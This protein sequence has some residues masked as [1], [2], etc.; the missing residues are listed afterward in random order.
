VTVSSSDTTRR[1]RRWV[2][3]AVGAAAVVTLA[4]TGTEILRSYSGPVDMHGNRVRAEDAVPPISKSSAVPA[5]GDDR[6]VVKSVGL[7]VPLGALNAVDGV[8]EPPGFTSAYWVRNEGVPPKE[9]RK[10]TV[11]VVMHSLRNGATGPGN[12]LIDV[13]RRTSKVGIGAKIKV[14]DTT[15][16]VTGTQEIDKPDIAHASAIWEDKPGRLVVITCLQRPD[17]GRSQQNVVIEASRS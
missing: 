16:T 8:I 4:I 9:A 2:L 7:N 5:I 17:G 15:Y 14:D 3:L 1:R 13:D 6:F 11:F 12:Y 10:G